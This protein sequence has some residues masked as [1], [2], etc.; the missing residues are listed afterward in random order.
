MLRSKLYSL[1]SSRVYE[2]IFHIETVRFSPVLFNFNPCALYVNQIVTY[3]PKSES[4]KLRPN[5][6]VT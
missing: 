2:Q 1:F 5:Y 4:I 3:I 6:N